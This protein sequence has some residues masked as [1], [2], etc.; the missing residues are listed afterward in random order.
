MIPSP[1]RVKGGA[2]PYEPAVGASVELSTTA[3]EGGQ[4][5]EV[6]AARLLGGHAYGSRFMGWRLSV[7]QPSGP[8]AEEKPRPSSACLWRSWQGLHSD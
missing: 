6:V 5:A 4:G 2:R 8:V 3:P 1:A 7:G